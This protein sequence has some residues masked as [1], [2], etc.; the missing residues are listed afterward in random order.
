MPPTQSPPTLAGT[1]RAMARNNAWSNHRLLAA[2]AQLDQAAFEAPRVGFF[3]SLRATLNH[4]LLVDH[5]Y[6]DAL[7]GGTLGP[8]AWA[9]EQPCVTI[10]VFQAAQA[11]V[12]HRLVAHC[13]V[14]SDADLAIEVRVHRGQ[15]HA[16][17]SGTAVK[18]PQLDEFY[19]IA[20][21]PLRAAEFAELGWTEATVW[22][23][24]V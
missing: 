22:Q 8:A 23:P 16:I 9:D 3:P 5:F 20:E 12:D 7:E 2:V 15:A 10:A 18:P 11:A 13:D 6:V 24:K 17:M 4:L 19:S 14:L 21:A 1:F